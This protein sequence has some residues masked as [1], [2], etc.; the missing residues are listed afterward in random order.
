MLLRLGSPATTTHLQRMYA[1][2]V[3]HSHLVSSAKKSELH[4]VQCGVVE[5]SATAVLACKLAEAP[6]YLRNEH[7][8]PVT[9]PPP[10]SRCVQG[11][12]APVVVLGGR[13]S[14][15]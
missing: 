7:T 8:T 15:L 13:D 2:E 12:K 6:F 3:R 9:P 10:A 11:E 5:V 4:N 14:F 1:L